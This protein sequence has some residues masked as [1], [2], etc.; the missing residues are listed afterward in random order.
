MAAASARSASSTPS[1]AISTQ[2][3][4]PCCATW[5]RSPSAK[6]SRRSKP[7]VKKAS[8]IDDDGLTGHGLGAAHGDDHVGAIVLVGG[9]LQERSGGGALDLLG[10][11][12]SRR[13]GALQE[14]WRHA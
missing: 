3:C 6:W 9:P 5:P 12:I 14:A 10:A 8:G 1:R 4:S 7:S 13:A 11:E 2:R